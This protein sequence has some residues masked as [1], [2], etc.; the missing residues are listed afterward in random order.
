MTLTTALKARDLGNREPRSADRFPEIC[1][2]RLK[3]YYAR[4]FRFSRGITGGDD[5]RRNSDPERVR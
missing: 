1:A 5:G 3:R 4:L 2:A